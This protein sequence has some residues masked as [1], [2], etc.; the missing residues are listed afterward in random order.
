[1]SDL[2]DAIFLDRDGV[3][4]HNRANYVRGWRD[5]RIY[6]TSLIALRRL[7]VRLPRVKIVIITNQSAV[8]RGLTSR[9]TV[10]GINQQLVG[11]IESAGGRIDGVYLCPHAPAD[12]CD[13]RKPKP[14]LLYQASRQLHISLSRSILIGDAFTDLEAGHRAGIQHLILVKTG[15]G[16]QQ[17]K[18]GIG[19]PVWDSAII[20]K[21]LLEAVKHLT[22]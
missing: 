22:V 7:A 8:G 5:V 17:V 6:P 12:D 13:C 20:E 16:N 1:M 4:I 11:V 2:I 10:D 15:R 18:Q 3:I 19:S 9:Q 14:G 21:N